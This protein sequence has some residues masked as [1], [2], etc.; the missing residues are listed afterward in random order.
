MPS[1]TIGFDSTRRARP[2]V[3][4]VPGLDGSGPAHWQTIWEEIRTDTR[5]V[6]LGQWNLPHRNS[7][8]SKLD[9]A[10][11]SAGGPVILAAHSLGCVAVAWWAAFTAQPLGWPVA[12]AL[13]VA[14]ADVDQPGTSDRITPFA[15]IPRRALP[16]P[17]IV[18]AS[19]DD[20][21]IALDRARDIAGD[22][23]SS[24]VDVGSLGHI[25]ADSGLGAWSDGQA[26][27][28]RL[29][30]LADQ[31]PALEATLS[32]AESTQIRTPLRS[33]FARPRAA[34]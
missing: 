10:V 29:I 11:R 5:R 7:W 31:R 23:G 13:L 14:P 16:F 6:E 19:D 2:V 27:L 1:D 3:L 24:F 28:M 21:W 22:W 8:I 32:P 30:D 15:P 17:S 4:T 18:V 33:A 12:G 25:N 34:A 9:Q 26:W 20:P